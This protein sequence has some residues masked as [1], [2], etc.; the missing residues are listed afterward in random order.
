MRLLTSNAKIVLRDLGLLVQVVSLM[1]FLSVGV[2]LAFGEY[3]AIGPLLITVGISLVVGLG[4]YFGFRGAGETTLAHGLII[5]AVGWLSVSL[6]GALPFYLIARQPQVGSIPTVAHFA[7][8]LNALFEAVSGYTATGLT[9]ALRPEELPRTLQWWRSFME[10]IGGVGVIVLTLTVVAGPRAHLLYYAEARQEKIHPSIRSTVRTIWWIYLLYTGVSILLLRAAGMPW[11]DAVNHGMTGIATGGFS[12]RSGSIGSYGS[13]ALELVLLPVMVLGALSFAV[14]YQLLRERKPGVI[15][16]DGQSRWLL[17]L[18]MGGLALLAL[19]NLLH[20]RLPA[21]EGLRRSSFQWVSALTTTGF[22]TADI[23]RWSEAAKLL[24][25]LA[26]VLGGAAGSTAGGIK[27]IRTIVLVRGLRWRLRKLISPPDVL[28]KFR[29]G[30]HSLTDEEATSRL[31]DAALLLLLWGLFLALGVLIL[32]HLVPSEYSLSDVLF[33]VASA[34]SNVGL[35]VGITHPELPEMA[36]LILCFS[37]WIGRLEIIP[38][39]MLLRS[40]FVGLD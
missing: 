2:A 1:A 24:L 14:H 22:Q 19:E 40:L 4:L 33:E 34:Q 3:F 27:L 38:V 25:T 28:V 39:L 5:A 15:W 17:L 16:A 37:M 36:K 21:L 13:L 10:W 32:L 29:L 35:S 7:E 30:G 20:L 26:M 6:L 18:L 12:T 31:V 23:C 8:P 9:M 11:W